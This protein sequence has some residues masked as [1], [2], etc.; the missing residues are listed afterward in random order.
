M[1]RVGTGLPPGSL[2]IAVRDGRI[3]GVR[4]RAERERGKSMVTMDVGDSELAE[5]LGRAQAESRQGAV[6][7]K[8]L[9]DSRLG[10]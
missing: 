1:P 8:R 5:L 3:V 2:R 10:G 7:G 9:W 6:R 4:E